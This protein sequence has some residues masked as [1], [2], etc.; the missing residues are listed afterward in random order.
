MPGPLHGGPASSLRA[1]SVAARDP[2]QL[3]LILLLEIGLDPVQ[4]EH[5]DQYRQTSDG[6]SCSRAVAEKP[7]TVTGRPPL[8]GKTSPVR[9]HRT[10]T[11]TPALCAAA[12]RHVAQAHLAYAHRTVPGPPAAR[13]RC[14]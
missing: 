1:G 11:A 8:G 13:A 10:V 7:R 6:T 9:L 12:P 4:S 5:D 3:V 14:R 2:R